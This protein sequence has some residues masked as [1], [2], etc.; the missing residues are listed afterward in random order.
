MELRWQQLDNIPTI[1]NASNAYI[2]DQKRSR[3]L[4]T[5]NFNGDA[6]DLSVVLIDGSAGINYSSGD[7]LNVA[8][9]GEVH[10]MAKSS[11]AQPVLIPSM[12]LQ[13]LASQA[14][15]GLTTKTATISPY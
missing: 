10:P 11:C 9:R 8:S 6:R 7:R 15:K 4:P 14:L 12:T 5:A 3:F 2:I 13:H 1:T